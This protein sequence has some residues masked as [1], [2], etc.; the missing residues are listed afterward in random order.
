MNTLCYE[1][2]WP[3]GPVNRHSSADPSTSHCIIKVI[4]H[5]VYQPKHKDLQQLKTSIRDVS[6]T[7]TH[8]TLQNKW[9]DATYRLDICLVD[10]GR[11]VGGENC[12]L[13]WCKLDVCT[14][15]MIRTRVLTFYLPDLPRNTEVMILDVLAKIRARHLSNTNQKHFTALSQLTLCSST[16]QTKTNAHKAFVLITTTCPYLVQSKYAGDYTWAA[17]YRI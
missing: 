2:W 1:V 10:V 14:M 5:L 3:R 11:G 7:V 9:T 13:W 16:P 8:N 17:V 12:L 6:A 15:Q 4:P